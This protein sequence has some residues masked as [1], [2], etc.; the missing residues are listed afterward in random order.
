MGHNEGLTD[1]NSNVIGIDQ[2]RRQKRIA[3][4]I[5]EGVYNFLKKK[6]LLRKDLEQVEKKEKLLEKSKGKC[7]QANEEIERERL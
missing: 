6:N 3:E 2:D 1:D 7:S 5:S 4:I